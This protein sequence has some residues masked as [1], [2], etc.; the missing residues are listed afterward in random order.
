MICEAVFSTKVEQEQSIASDVQRPHHRR[1][2][3]GVCRGST[4]KLC[5]QGKVTSVTVMPILKSVYSPNLKGIL[6]NQNN[7]K[8]KPLQ[9][10]ETSRSELNSS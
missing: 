3:G 4:V 6:E 7:L 1:L 9:V 10:K 8:G 5:E 2:L